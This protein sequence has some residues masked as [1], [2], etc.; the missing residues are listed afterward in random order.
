LALL[1][2]QLLLLFAGLRACRIGGVALQQRGA[3]FVLASELL[4]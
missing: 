1:L 3:A 4:R 2:Q